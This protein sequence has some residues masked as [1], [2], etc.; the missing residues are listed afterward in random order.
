MAHQRNPP[1]GQLYKKL[2]GD[3][4]EVARVSLCRVTDKTNK[5]KR[6][7]TKTTKHPS[8]EAKSSGQ[9]STTVSQP[10]LSHGTHVSQNVPSDKIYQ[11][12]CFTYNREMFRE[13]FSVAP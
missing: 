9:G 8:L 5:N 10:A 2:N 7:Q 11:G 4:R 13:V 12:T 3:N 1:P 6:K